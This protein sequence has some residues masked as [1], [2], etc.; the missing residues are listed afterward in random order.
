MKKIFLLLIL[1][2]IT[3]LS[4]SDNLDNT[5][6]T[7]S[8]NIDNLTK[9]APRS[10]NI[11]PWL[12]TSRLIDGSIGCDFIYDTTFVNTQGKEV[13]VYARLKIEPGAFNGTTK[14]IMLPNVENLSIKLYP[15]MIFNKEVKLSLIFT[16]IDLKT[17]GYETTDEI[18][19]AYFSDSGDIK[20]IE[21]D[22]S[23]VNIPR[24]HIKVMNAVLHHFSRYGWIR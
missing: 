2:G 15:E 11:Y 22:L 18:E 9:S 21:S 10:F 6:V 4:C 3:F 16:G 14:I 24:D 7:T 1:V 23:H 20:L 8:N 12:Y 19:F 5:I 17:F 13:N